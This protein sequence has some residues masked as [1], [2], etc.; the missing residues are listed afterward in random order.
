MILLWKSELLLVVL[1]NFFSIYSDYSGSQSKNFEIN[2]E[3]EYLLSEMN[4]N[5]GDSD[6]YTFVANYEDGFIATGKDGRIEWISS[7]G[8]VNKTEKFPGLKFNCL[9]TYGSAII[10]AGEEGKVLISS[11]KETFNKIES[12]TDKDINTLTLFNNLV[13]AGTDDG[14]LLLGDFDGFFQ[15]IQL[16]LKG[17]IVSLSARSSDCYG[18]TD[19]GEIIHTEDGINWE[20]FDFNQEYKGFYKACSFTSVLVTEN[21]IAVTGINEDGT[22]AVLFSNQGGVWTERSLNYTD[23]QGRDGYL[24]D[25]PYD[26]FFDTYG[27]EFYITCSNGKLL[28]LPSCTHCNE[29]GVI[30]EQ[31]LTGISGFENT[32]LIVGEDYFIKAITIR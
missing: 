6:G 3:K 23:M 9:V 26:I 11:E 1:G 7:E 8:K 24:T 2:S 16:D 20:I 10:A 14:E 15:I 22:P 29:V 13:I 5:S 27:N 18:V 32:L 17:N 30:S 31:N 28:K 19:K 12:G 21:R 4:V 25:V